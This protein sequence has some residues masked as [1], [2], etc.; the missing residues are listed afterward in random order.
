[1]KTAMKAWADAVNAGTFDELDKYLATDM[2]DHNSAID[3]EGKLEKDWL[4]GIKRL[5]MDDR[6]KDP[7]SK[8][9]IEDMMTE[10]DKLVCRYVIVG[11]KMVDSADV[12]IPRKKYEATSLWARWENGK[13]VELWFPKEN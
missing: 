12:K 11:T 5:M 6:K 10:G 4:P 8:V 3:R 1:M 7:G 2:I 9:T 13:F